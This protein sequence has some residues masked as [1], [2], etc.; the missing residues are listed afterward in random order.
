MGWCAGLAT[1]MTI[2]VSQNSIIFGI[3]SEYAFGAAL[4]HTQ[5]KKCKFF[6]QIKVAPLLCGFLFVE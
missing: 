4:G 5:I 6:K 1:G 2:G 3:G